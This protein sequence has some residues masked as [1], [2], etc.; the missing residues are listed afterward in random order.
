[1]DMV[2]TFTKF[3]KHKSRIISSVNM[4]AIN[5]SVKDCLE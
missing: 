4:Y 3:Q 2:E 1:M 5:K